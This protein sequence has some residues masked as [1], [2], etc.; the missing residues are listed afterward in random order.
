M[1]RSAFSAV[2]TIGPEGRVAHPLAYFTASV[3]PDIRPAA[4]NPPP[5]GI[6][7]T[8]FGPISAQAGIYRAPVPDPQQASD[9]FSRKP[10]LP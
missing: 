8:P 1:G 4:R 2:H 10:F 7:S 6:F 5:A 9:H 3:A